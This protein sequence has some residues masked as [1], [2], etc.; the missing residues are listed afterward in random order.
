MASI[1][2]FGHEYLAHPDKIDDMGPFDHLFLAEGDSWMDRSSLTQLSLPYYLAMEL[3]KRNQSVL[4]INIAKAG[5]TLRNITDVL[6]GEFMWWLKQDT[7]D[8]ILFSAGGNDFI[9]AARDEPAGQGLLH[10]M[11]G[12]PLPANGYDCVDQNALAALVKNYLDPNFDKLAAAV[13]ATPKNPNT[14]IYLNSYDTPTARNAPAAP[15]IGPWLY[16]A[17][18]KNSVNPL[19]WPALTAGIFNDVKQTIDGWALRNANVSTVPTTGVLT[20]SAAGS[21]GSDAD[22]ANEIHP[23]AAGWQKLAKVWA[24]ALGF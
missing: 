14:P 17:Y 11:A 5:D 9:N 15:G 23:N 19:L 7:Y 12:L 8:G 1:A 22:W 16:T 24:T 4:I 13:R 6:Q 10:D 18:R 2:V 3:N 21:T 20:P